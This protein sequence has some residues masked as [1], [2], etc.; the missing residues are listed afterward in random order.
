MYSV[1]RQ[2]LGGR[3]KGACA[4]GA[5][6]GLGGVGG[7]AVFAG[8][9][10]WRR[11]SIWG[12][13]REL[14]VH[15]KGHE[16]GGVYPSGRRWQGAAGSAGMGDTKNPGV[17]RVM[18]STWAQGKARVAASCAGPELGG[19]CTWGLRG[20]PRPAGGGTMEGEEEGG[21]GAVCRGTVCV[22]DTAVWGCLG[23]VGGSWGAGTSP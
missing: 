18:S 5:N 6:T 13:S 16:G 22:G 8:V 2:R 12:Q 3:E 20:D 14:P 19:G 17:G 11:V 15:F 7:E 9:C 4:W 1:G 23:P 21:S 10:V